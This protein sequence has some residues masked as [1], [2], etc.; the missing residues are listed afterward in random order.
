MPQK[1]RKPN[2]V[3]SGRLWEAARVV[4]AGLVQAGLVQRASDSFLRGI[5]AGLCVTCLAISQSAAA[6]HFDVFQ[7][8]V[9]RA[10]K[11]IEDLTARGIVLPEIDMEDLTAY[12]VAA[13]ATQRAVAAAAD[14][15]SSSTFKRAREPSNSNAPMS[16]TLEPIQAP[17]VSNELTCTLD[18]EMRA[19]VR[20]I[21]EDMQGYGLLSLPVTDGKV[22][23]VAAAYLCVKKGLSQVLAASAAGI[24]QS[25]VSQMKR[26]VVELVALGYEL[27]DL[28]FDATK[29]PQP[30]AARTS[31]PVAAHAADGVPDGAEL[32]PPQPP[33]EEGG[34]EA[35]GEALAADVEPPA[36]RPR[37]SNELLDATVSRPAVVA[38]MLELGEILLRW[39]VVQRRSD[40]SLRCAA[41]AH[42]V[43]V[44]G[45]EPKHAAALFGRQQAQVSGFA[46]KLEEMLAQG[47]VLPAFDWTIF[48]APP[49]RAPR[50]GGTAKVARAQARAPAAREEAGA[51]L[52]DGGEMDAAAGLASLAAGLVQSSGHIACALPLQ[53]SICMPPLVEATTISDGCHPPALVVATAIDRTAGESQGDLPQL[54]EA[55]AIVPGTLVGQMG[56]DSVLSDALATTSERLSLPVQTAVAVALPLKGAPVTAASREPRP[57]TAETVEELD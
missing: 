25:G 20:E 46:L 27:P 29:I 3:S 13:A 23:A 2:P 36:K 17:R 38:L 50:R 9:S 14:G 54:I 57:G 5:A 51:A 41:A 56:A 19:G 8:Q 49:S 42:A 39:N 24:Y 40:A 26:K 55:T 48:P 34:G 10:K 43:L 47:C 22:R 12:S 16:P 18:E 15:Q 7:P 37:H 21:C 4:G 31:V 45:L 53:E 11:L 33:R 32:P 1:P 52:E 28:P 6:T 44:G 35:V 30:Q